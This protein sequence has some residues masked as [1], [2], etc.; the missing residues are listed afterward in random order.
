M[1][2][3]ERSDMESHPVASLFPLMGDEEFAA[4][5]QRAMVAADTLILRTLVNVRKQ[6]TRRR[7]GAA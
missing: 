7:T 6:T 4:N 1:S 2:Q 3:P 5:G